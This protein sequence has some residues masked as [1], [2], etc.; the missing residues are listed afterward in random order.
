GNWKIHII[1]IE[2]FQPFFTII[3]VAILILLMSAAIGWI[4][5]NTM[6][7][8][9]ILAAK[10]KKQAGELAKSELQFR[11]ILNQAAIGMA[12]VDSKSGMILETNKRFQQ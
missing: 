9:A 6:K 11:T 3:P 8:P 12:R 5:F 10:V 4:I 7:Q 2:P 1:P